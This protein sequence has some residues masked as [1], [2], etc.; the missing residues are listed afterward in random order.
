MRPNPAFQRSCLRQAAEGERHAGEAA[1]PASVSLDALEHAVMWV[2]SPPEFEAEAYVSRTT[3]KIYSRGS[4]GPIEDDYPE[5]V[6]D[7]IEYV[8]IPHK[9]ELELGRN[10]ALRFVDECAPQISAQVRD[11]FHGKGAYGRFKALLQR[12]RLLERWHEYENEAIARALERWAEEQ[13]FQVE[14]DRPRSNSPA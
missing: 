13:G 5:D 10:L 2:S 11:A 14:H 6:E 7:G 4:D 8:A 9:N 1:M 3:G 12:H